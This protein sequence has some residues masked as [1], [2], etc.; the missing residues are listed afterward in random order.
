MSGDSK[1]KHH[2]LVQELAKDHGGEL[3]ELF[4]DGDGTAIT[5]L[6]QDEEVEGLQFLKDDQ[7][8]R[9]PIRPHA[10]LVNVGDF[11]ESPVHRAATNSKKERIPVAMFCIPEVGK[12]IGPIEE[13]ID[14]KRP[15]LYKD[16]D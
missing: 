9:V 8:V 2:K 12:D 10:L 11:V 6:L 14:D 15:T 16:N 4:A 13:L 7:W 5:I 1:L 3:P